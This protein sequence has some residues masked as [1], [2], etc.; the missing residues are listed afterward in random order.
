MGLKQQYLFLI[1]TQCLFSSGFVLSC[2]H[3]QIQ[4]DHLV[5]LRYFCRQVTEGFANCI[6]VPKPSLA[7]QDTWPQL[8]LRQKR[9][10][11]LLYQLP[12]PTVNTRYNKLLLRLWLCGLAGWWLM[13]A[14][15]G[16]MVLLIIIRFIHISE[17]GSASHLLHLLLGNSVFKHVLLLIM[18]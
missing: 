11:I 1:S 10:V 2:L 6:S 15:L 9:H 14:G 12:M 16:R 13:E 18:G 5:C 8:D 7:K 17:P 3:L 4:I